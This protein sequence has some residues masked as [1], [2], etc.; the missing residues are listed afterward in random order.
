MMRRAR[1]S[2]SPGPVVTC[3]HNHDDAASGCEALVWEQG[4]ISPQAKGLATMT[5]TPA[6]AAAR[7]SAP[8]HCDSD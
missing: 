6:A 7:G 2:E 4:A 1:R 3:D 5:D 8:S